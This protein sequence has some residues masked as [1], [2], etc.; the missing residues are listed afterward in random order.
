LTNLFVKSIFLT[1]TSNSDQ[2]NIVSNLIE[3]IN[4]KIVGFLL[5]CN[6][7]RLHV[8]AIYLSV[9]GIQFKL[10]Y[11]PNGRGQ[12]SP[13]KCAAPLLNRL[14][15][16]YH[17]LNLAS[18]SSSNPWLN[19]SKRLV[20]LGKNLTGQAEVGSQRKRE[21]EKIRR[22]EVKPANQKC[23]TRYSSPYLAQCVNFAI[24]LTA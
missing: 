20:E 23:W 6:E 24:S 3:I 18:L 19:K 21:D 10:W 5:T 1:Q 9:T 17:E 16:H 13:V 15:C 12:R 2:S 4:S 22:W 11:R 14:C 7:S 8:T